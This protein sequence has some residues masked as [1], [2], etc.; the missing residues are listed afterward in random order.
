MAKQNDSTQDQ[1]MQIY[2]QYLS[3]NPDAF[4]YAVG[5]SPSS[6]DLRGTSS[7]SPYGANTSDTNKRYVAWQ[8]PHGG[9]SF[10]GIDA[11]GRKY[12]IDKET[13]IDMGYVPPTVAKS[14]EVGT[15]SDQPPQTIGGSVGDGSSY[16]GPGGG[17]YTPPTTGGGDP[18]TP[19]PSSGGGSPVYG[20]GGG[21][22]YDWSFEGGTSGAPPLAGGGGYNPEDYNFERYVPGQES[23]WGVPEVEG[24]NKDFYR[25]Q[26]MNLLREEQNFQNKEIGVGLWRQAQ[27][28]NPQQAADP[29]DWTTV[30]VRPPQVAQS[31]EGEGA[32]PYTWV[33]RNGITPGQTSNKEIL[34]KAL[35]SGGISQQQFDDFDQSGY[36]DFYNSNSWSNTTSPSQASS[37][38][39]G[40]GT[41]TS[42]DVRI[43]DLMNWLHT[44]QDLT[45]PVGGGP[46]AAPGY[47][48]PINVGAS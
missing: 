26:F 17:G 27:E 35:S 15:P 6:M 28:N 36:P 39:I 18:F 19:P 8:N 24:G 11:L 34:A 2:N 3:E 46:T 22:G 30:G 12:Q 1:R 33:M 45:T 32:D 47:A 29:F 48:L 43:N 37:A 5:G 13:A 42:R 41:S 7:T 40:S 20:G 44:R 23:P 16:Y 21:G 14:F 38:N 4:N 25:N 31:G 9:S 10:I